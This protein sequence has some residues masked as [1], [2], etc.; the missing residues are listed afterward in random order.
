M[1]NIVV[2]FFNHHGRPMSAADVELVG[3]KLVAKSP[4]TAELE[5]KLPFGVD[6]EGVDAVI[7]NDSHL[8]VKLPY[9]PIAHSRVGFPLA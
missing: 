8:L 9:A 6:W 2:S 4:G 1:Q 7:Q 3:E 5:L